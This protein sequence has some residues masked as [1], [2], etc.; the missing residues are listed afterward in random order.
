MYLHIGNGVTVKKK[1]IIGIFDMDTATVSIS[2][3]KFLSDMQ[4]KKKVLYGESDIPRSFILLNGEE[5]GKYKI[6]LSKISAVGLNARI[7]NEA[8]EI[9]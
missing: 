6:Y 7:D 9:L 2:S 1:D 3:R 4:K 8:E 5:K